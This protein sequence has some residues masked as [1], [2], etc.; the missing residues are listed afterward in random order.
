MVKMISLSLREIQLAELEILKW[1][2]GFCR[3]K[4]LKYSLHAGT[5]L[6]A[7]RHEGFI[8]WDD[9]LDVSM[10]RADY[11]RFVQ[12][13]NTA[14]S[15]LTI[16]SNKNSRLITPFVKLCNPKIRMQEQ[17]YGSDVEEYLWVDVFPLDDAFD[18]ES[19]TRECLQ[20]INR[21]LG[22]LR[23]MYLEHP[24]DGR[25]KASVRRFLALFNGG[26]S[27]R[28]RLLEKIDATVTRVSSAQSQYLTS[29]FEETDEPIFI[30]K[31][32]Y[33]SSVEI[34]FEGNHF[35]AMSCFDKYLTD[36]YGEYMV[37]PPLEKRTT[38]SAKAWYV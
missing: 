24:E 36:A 7:I 19:Q 13:F 10:P 33:E 4:G 6:G 16:V 29:Y 3:D 37:L 35:L 34:N 32:D 26:E 18:D 15:D 22:S 21:N 28:R 9:D 27:G 5:L 20:S 17:S 25:I 14:Q 31:K 2:D 23:R 30:S 8:P 1:F 12:L 38:H 11:E